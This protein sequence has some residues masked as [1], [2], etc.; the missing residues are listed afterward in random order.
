M[1]GILVGQGVSR[2]LLE[3]D[4]SRLVVASWLFVAFIAG[5]AY[6]SSLFASLTVPKYPPRPE[7][8]QELVQT[9]A[10]WDNTQK[11]GRGNGHGN[12]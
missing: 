7:S 1:V 5:V 11:E 2:K 8:L 6:R 12:I 10:R 9:E 3:L 4:S